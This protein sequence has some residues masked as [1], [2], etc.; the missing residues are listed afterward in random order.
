[1]VEALSMLKSKF[2]AVPVAGTLPVPVHPVHARWAKKD[3]NMG[4]FT[5]A[6]MAV[7]AS[8][9]SLLGVGEP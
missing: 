5:E 3:S 8:N 1:M 7:P 9:Q 6:D 2:A 4:E